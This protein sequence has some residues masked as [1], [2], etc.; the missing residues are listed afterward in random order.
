MKFSRNNLAFMSVLAAGVLLAT[1][2]FVLPS[3]RTFGSETDE[4]NAAAV[5]QSIAREQ[6]AAAAA[7]ANKPAPPAASAP[8][9]QAP[10][11]PAAPLDNA[12]AAPSGNST[13]GSPASESN[14][15]P[16]TGDGGYLSGTT[17]TNMGFLLSGLGV[18]LLGSGS[19][20]W[21]VGRKRR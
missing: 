13:A 14:G 3:A 20:V 19:L 21:A 11:P 16:S 6:A 5:A 17:T 18:V 4:A 8:A 12:P 7:A 1:A 10:A 9:A 2:T 15:L